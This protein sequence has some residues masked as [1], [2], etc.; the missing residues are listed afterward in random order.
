MK[1]K[2]PFE[3]QQ[4]S[5]DVR[6]GQASNI[7]NWYVV[8]IQVARYK[9]IGSVKTQYRWGYFGVGQ[10]VGFMDTYRSVVANWRKA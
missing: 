4:R 5:N 1:I 9:T 3:L 2:A 10:F 6:A 7:S 8:P